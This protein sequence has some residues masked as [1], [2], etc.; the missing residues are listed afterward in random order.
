M[1]SFEETPFAAASIGQVHHVQLLDGR[2][3]AMK[4]QYPG[5]AEGIESDINN[6]MTVLK[7]W[8]IFPKGIFQS[9]CHNEKF[10]FDI[11]NKLAAF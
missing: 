7:V 2:H 11:V 5:V 6:L 9:L 10:C 1:T 4:I 8:D 3:A